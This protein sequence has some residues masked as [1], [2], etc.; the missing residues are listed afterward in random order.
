MRERRL[1]C[2]VV[3]SGA[4]ANARPRAR[5]A[6]HVQNWY[7]SK[8][9]A[10]TKYTTQYTTGERKDINAELTRMKKY[11]T[12]I[13]VIAHTQSRKLNLRAK[14]AH[15]M[16]IQ[17]NGGSVSDQVDFGARMFEQEVKVTDVF[18][19]SEKIDILGVTKGYGFEGVIGRWCVK[20][21]PRKTHRG[22]RK[23]ACIGAWHPARV[24]WTVSRAGQRGYHHRTEQ[25]K[26]I[27]RVGKAVEKGVVDVSA[28]TEQDL[29]EKG[30][31]PLGGFPHYGVV[32]NDW[33]MLRGCCIG[34]TGV[35]VTASVSNGG[36]PCCCG[37]AHVFSCVV[38]L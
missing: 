32:K 21:L 6:P 37:R 30:I 22:L 7:R 36:R 2:C 38:G 34:T 12:V 11:C 10:F 8:Q 20:R 4:L 23:V 31:T 35:T 27:F 26:S 5:P 9:K 33:L 3:A 14:K 19:E 29:T 25:N 18:K 17:V 24:S 15:V 1:W 13:R 16:E 28:Q